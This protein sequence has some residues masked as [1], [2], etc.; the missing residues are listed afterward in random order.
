MSVK[1]EENNE[2]EDQRGVKGASAAAASVPHALEVPVSVAVVDAKR[3]IRHRED[4]GGVKGTRAACIA[5]A[6]EVPGSVAVVGVPSVSRCEVDSSP[7]A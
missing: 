7:E 2:R 6:L 5:Y 4:R 1:I 3:G